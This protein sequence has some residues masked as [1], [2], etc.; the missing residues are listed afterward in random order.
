MIELHWAP[1]DPPGDSAPPPTPSGAPLIT[2]LNEVAP[3]LVVE[4][5]ESILA[6]L[7][8]I[9]S[10]EGYAAV[11]AA[12]GVEALKAI[13]GVRPSLILLD[14]RMPHMNGWEFV[15]VLKARGVSSPVVVM[16]AAENAQVWASEVGA[17]GY[18]TK[19]F[20]FVA[21]LEVVERHRERPPR[22]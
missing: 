6:M 3:I 4:D 15:R 5:D 14:M 13:D 11:G 16:T 10:L 22:N 2:R 8:N 19:P 20:D 17:A 7:M 12:N 1:A 18:V 21:L 9:L